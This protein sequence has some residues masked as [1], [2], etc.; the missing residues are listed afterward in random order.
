MNRAPIVLSALAAAGLALAGC[1]SSEPPPPFSQVDPYTSGYFISLEGT[2]LAQDQGQERLYNLG[3]NACAH[4]DKGDSVSSEIQALTT[5]ANL[6]PA[7]ANLVAAAVT[8]LCPQHTD[9]LKAFASQ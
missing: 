4:L 9:A 7:A 1:G 3:V 8:E 6:G 5:D 2:G